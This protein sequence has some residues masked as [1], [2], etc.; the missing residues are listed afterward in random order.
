MIIIFALA[1]N[2]FAQNDV[3]ITSYD[4]RHWRIE[5]VHDGFLGATTCHVTKQGMA[6]D[7]NALVL[8]LGSR[9]D[10]SHA[11]FRIDDGVPVAA[12]SATSP[13]SSASANLGNPS[14]GA[15]EVPLSLLQGP[16]KK[17]AVRADR[18]APV[19]NFDISDI[20]EALAMA[21]KL[22]CS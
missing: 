9:V 7:R 3:T 2:L 10:T 14:D 11:Y 8:R 4:V 12:Y 18:R 17:I 19:R 13:W 21:K 1:L 5:V 6:V 22:S 16:N 15:I 20:Y